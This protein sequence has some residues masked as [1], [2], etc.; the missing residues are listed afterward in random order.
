[1]QVRR[2]RSHHAE[3]AEGK[4]VGAR[5]SPESFLRALGLMGGGV[6]AARR[7]SPGSMAVAV[8]PWTPKLTTN[9]AAGPLWVERMAVIW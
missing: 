9:W 7:M 8:T 5:K 3:D 6:Q 4:W 1:M 2:V